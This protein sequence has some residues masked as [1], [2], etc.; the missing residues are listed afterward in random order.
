MGSIRALRDELVRNLD[1]WS[2]EFQ[3]GDEDMRLSLIGGI[4]GRASAQYEALMRS[5]LSHLSNHESGHE[6]VLVVGKGKPIDRLTAGECVKVL[7]R[8]DRD[9]AIEEHRRLLTRDDVKRLERVSRLRS[10]V[11]HGRREPDVALGREFVSDLHDICQSKL[12]TRLSE[13]DQSEGPVRPIGEQAWPRYVVLP[14]GT[15][16]RASR[17]QDRTEHD[18]W[19]E[20][21]LYLDH[22]WNPSW[23]HEYIVWPDFQLP[24]EPADAAR[25]IAR[26]YER[27]RA[28]T[29]VE[30]GCHGGVG[31]T[32][33]ALAC[34]AIL[35]GVAP[36]EAVSWVRERFYSGA[37]DT[38]EQEEWVVGFPDISSED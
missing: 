32:G 38:I 17:L 19:R 37:I 28:G 21:G 14:D 9:R 1:R 7:E 10:D 20:F 22:R 3:H 15:R 31:R 2:D 8:L 23:D 30:V 11:V 35:A 6:V 25:K 13:R 16:V 4:I 34:M 24:S 18:G 12:L 33:T 27:A 36:E 29:H 5:C 26:V